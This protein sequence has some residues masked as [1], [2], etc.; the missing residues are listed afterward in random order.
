M[1]NIISICTE[2]IQAIDLMDIECALYETGMLLK[3]EHVDILLE[4]WVYSLGMSARKIKTDSHAH[5]FRICLEHLWILLS[6]EHLKI[7]DCFG[8]TVE[9]CL[10]VKRIYSIRFELMHLGTYKKKIQTLFPEGA[11]LSD[12]GLS[13]FDNILP[14]SKDPSYLLAIRIAAGFTRLWGDEEW[15]ESRS[16]LEY[17]SRRNLEIK[18]TGKFVHETDDMLWYLWGLLNNYFGEKTVAKCWDV[19][20]FNYQNKRKMDRIALLWVVPLYAYAC[21]TSSEDLE[22]CWESEDLQLLHKVAIQ[23]KD[24]WK[25][26]DETVEQEAENPKNVLMTYMP[27]VVHTQVV[28]PVHDDKPKHIKLSSRYAAL[29]TLESPKNKERNKEV[30]KET[31]NETYSINSRNRGIYSYRS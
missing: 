7:K 4:S 3:K 26:L 20:Y 19:F 18:N 5:I 11:Q 1:S 8:M 17:L 27:R 14:K 30:S 15:T 16:S 23:T 2:L 31:D 29:E 24:L 6:T 21:K 12:K 25:Q 28:L 10:L 9:L 13:V 22:M